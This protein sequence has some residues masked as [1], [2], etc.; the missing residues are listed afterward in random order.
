MR[1][2]GFSTWCSTVYRLAPGNREISGALALD[3]AG[4]TL[5]LL[6]LWHIYSGLQYHRYRIAIARGEL[7]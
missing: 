2:T 4:K 6:W 1:A 5:G 3:P 7:K